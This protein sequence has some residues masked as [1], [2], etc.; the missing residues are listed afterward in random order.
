MKKYIILRAN[1]LD[2]LEDLVNSAMAGQYVP[3]GGLIRLPG[4]D[5]RDIWY[6][7]AMVLK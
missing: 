6:G 3:V 5:R 4:D 2:A 1:C 7:Q